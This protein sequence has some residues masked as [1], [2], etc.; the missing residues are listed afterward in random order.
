MIK[1]IPTNFKN[2]YFKKN[3]KIKLYIKNNLKQYFYAIRFTKDEHELCDLEMK[4]LFNKAPK[5]NYIFSYHY[6]NPHR[7]PFI[8]QCISILYTGDTVDAIISQIVSNNLYYEDF[9]V[10][11]FNVGNEKFSYQEKRKIEYKVG[12]KINGEA[13]VHNPKIL[14]GL[15]KVND[16]WIFGELE[17]ND[18]P[19]LEHNK[20]PYSY[21]NALNVKVSRAIVNI[22]VANNLKAK[23]VDPC[24]GIGTVVVEALSLG[25]DITGFEINDF[26]SE[27]AQRNLE[28]LGFKN[29]VTTGDMHQI[30][31]KYDVAIIDL[32]YGLFSSTTL[33]EQLALVKTARRIADKM[34]IISLSNMDE[35]YISCGFQIVD[36]CHIS[37]G[38]FK[39]YLTICK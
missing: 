25:I 20:K 9:K 27:N 22:A 35:H 7:S 2:S 23:V 34:V 15:T 12:Y 33:E 16:K 26:I 13:D 3:L 5:L 17:L 14:L 38:K 29:V 18:S 10:C 8:K 24:C 36:N 32:P 39:R 37:K 31:D 28:F 11:Y 6:E 21:C 30:K 1:S 4:C 19:W